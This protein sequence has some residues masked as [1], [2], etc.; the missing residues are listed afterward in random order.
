MVIRET[1][2]QWIHLTQDRVLCRALVSI[3][4]SLQVSGAS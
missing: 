4:I 1:G 3:V 2:V